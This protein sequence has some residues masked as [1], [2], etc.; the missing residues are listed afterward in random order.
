MNF[1]LTLAFGA[2]LGFFSLALFIGL[3][4]GSAAITFSASLAIVGS[5]I[6]FVLAKN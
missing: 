5:M 1:W 2:W 4:R 6:I 3:H